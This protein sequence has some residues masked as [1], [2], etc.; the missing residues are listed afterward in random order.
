MLEYPIQ[1][2]V[3]FMYMHILNILGTKA[4]MEQQLDDTCPGSPQRKKA[5][6]TNEN[7]VPRTPMHRQKKNTNKEKSKGI[8]L[9]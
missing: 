4:E 1:L 9:P 8:E 3:N 2:Y 7:K 5:K 6:T